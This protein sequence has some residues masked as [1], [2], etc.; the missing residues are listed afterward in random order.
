MALP[1][2]QQAISLTERA[3]HTLLLVPEKPS[4][5]AFASMTAL[6]LALLMGKGAEEVDAVSPSHVPAA[7]Q[8]LPGSSQVKMQ[9]REQ[10][11][12]VVDI[13][14]PAQ[15]VALREEPLSGGVRIHVVFPPGVSLTKDQ[16]E[17]VVR[18]L[19]YD[20][21]II[22][23]AADLEELGNIFTQH[24]D[25]FYSTPI[26]NIDH[27][28]KN[29]HFGTVN[30]VDITA[31]SVAEVTYHLINTLPDA[32]PTPDLATC[33]YAGI[34][35]ATDSF[36]KPSTTPQAFQ[37]AADLLE[38]EADKESV[39]QHIVKTK[40]L[41]LLK[42]LGRSFARLQHE[43]GGGL[44]WSILR[45]IDFEE[46]NA[47]PDIIP[48]VMRELTNNIAGFNAAFI[49]YEQRLGAYQVHLLLG[50][51]LLNR[52]EEIQSELSAEKQN[53]AL[54]L[55][56]SAP[57]LEAATHQALEKIRGILP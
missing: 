29:E 25:F 45:P 49:L 48:D 46:S 30:I 17:T 15:T 2:L 41:S 16:I 14:G 44:Y 50:K 40:P 24:T 12:V 26:I 56:L 3:S 36:Q 10:S 47:A 55:R 33:L 5:D 31:S 21:A 13:A 22:L 19:P 39:I 35:S 20:L 57:S 7:L 4:Y 54:V 32:A 38:R 23:G 18:P 9:P 51:G 34:V 11:D 43:E 53:S 1:E 27:R 28:A 6:Y 37:L 8:F 42:L 52:R